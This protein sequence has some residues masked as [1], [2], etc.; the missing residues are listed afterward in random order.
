MSRFATTLTAA[1]GFA[2]AIGVHA[3]ET[4]V[5]SK[6][7]AK[8]DEAKTVTYTGCVQTGT[9]TRSYILDKVVPVSRT[10]T[11]EA[12][13]T[14][15][16]STT[17]TTTYALVPGEKVEFQ[18]HVGHKVEVTGLLLPGGDVKSE[19][20]TKT[21]REDAPDTTMKEK[22]KGKGVL[23]QLRVISVKQLAESC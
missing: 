18:Q 8:G 10:T 3:Q 17:T 6:T 11:T 4:T 12:V 23:P 22:T 16:T 20:K 5:Q 2:F 21:E 15:G 19:T 13:G 7:K 14:S 9:E 1:L